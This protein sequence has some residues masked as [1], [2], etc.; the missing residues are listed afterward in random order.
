MS[1][2]ERGKGALNDK[3]ACYVGRVCVDHEW[4]VGL[5]GLND[6]EHGS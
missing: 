5:W 2:K 6:E 3:P 1:G 4:A